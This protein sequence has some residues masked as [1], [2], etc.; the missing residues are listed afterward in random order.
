MSPERESLLALSSDTG[1]RPETLEK[2]IR[3]GELLGDI[4]RHP[5]LSRALALKGGTAINLAFGEPR[6]LSVDL[7]FNYVGAS[8]RAEMLVER[9]D[10]ERAITN[11]AGG[12]HYAT[13]QSSEEHG[14]RKFFLSYRNVHQAPD[15]IEID[16]NF[17]FRV[18]LSDLTSLRMWQPPGFERPLS[19]SVGFEELATGKILALLDRVAPRDVYDVALIRLIR[20]EIWNSDR[21]RTIFVALSSIL[22]HPLHS[23]GRER[24]NGVTEG[25]IRTELT[26]MLS[27][28]E[29]I[30]RV[31][32]S[33]KAWA[34]VSPLLQLT[35]AEREFVDLVQQGELA[36]ELLFSD[37][38]LRANILRHPAI[39]WKIEN[40]RG[41][42]D[43][44]R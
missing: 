29:T 41:R 26:P 32:L 7:D 27:S 19:K 34:A 39:L 1:F 18:P 36:P 31:E 9:P 23:Y 22:P 10:V 28:H 4:S 24:L 25:R 21:F 3:L 43:R 15:R 42:F 13:Q 16:I 35:D 17:L 2:V 12:R 6:R 40:A 8:D 33:A 14:G 37:A 44:S 30:S 11:I 20:P 38:E 5:L